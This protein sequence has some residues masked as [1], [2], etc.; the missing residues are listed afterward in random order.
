MR[1]MKVLGI[2]SF[3]ILY[4]LN[5]FQRLIQSI[6]QSKNHIQVVLCNFIIM[7]FHFI[8]VR[9]KI[10]RQCPDIFTPSFFCLLYVRYWFQY[11]ERIFLIY[12]FEMAYIQLAAQFD[13]AVWKVPLNFSFHLISCVCT[14]PVVFHGLLWM[15]PGLVVLLCWRGK[16]LLK[17][18]IFY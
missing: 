2:D 14:L 18:F 13:A 4:I 15:S 17:N 3:L 7:F 5:V 10:R 11:M 16:V 1:I 6:L 8:K 9:L 12:W